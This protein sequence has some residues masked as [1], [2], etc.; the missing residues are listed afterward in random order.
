[1]G[2]V[3]SCSALTEESRIGGRFR[4][5]WCRADALPS[6]FIFDIQVDVTVRE[7]LTR[8]CA[9]DSKGSSVSLT[10]D[11]TCSRPN[12]YGLREALHASVFCSVSPSGSSR[13]SWDA[14]SCT[15]G[16]MRSSMR[17]T[18]SFLHMLILEPVP[19]TRSDDSCSVNPGCTNG[20]PGASETTD[21]SRSPLT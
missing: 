5:L 7:G 21:P 9:R 10:P 2:R 11:G 15:S 18:R 20:L 19:K 12:A 16:T 8:T 14:N 6:E 1:L 13:T 4:L 3:V 17:P